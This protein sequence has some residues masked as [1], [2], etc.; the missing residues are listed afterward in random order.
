MSKRANRHRRFV[1]QH[2]REDTLTTVQK[3]KTELCNPF[4][5]TGACRYGAKCRFAHGES[6]MYPRPRHHLYKTRECKSYLKSGF[7]P[8]GNRCNFIHSSTT[9][10]PHNSPSSTPASTPPLSP[11]GSHEMI[12][13]TSL[14]APTP[15]PPLALGPWQ[16]V[17]FGKT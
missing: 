12:Y 15:S 14:L 10:T 2:H 16:N 11:R 9:T 8:Y 7:C 13:W 4:T 3:Y 5:E 17:L 6:D 1:Q